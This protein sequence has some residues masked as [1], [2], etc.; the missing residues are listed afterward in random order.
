MFILTMYS[1]LTLQP[2][3]LGL[4]TE[5]NEFT[6]RKKNQSDISRS[7]ILKELDRFCKD[8]RSFNLTPFNS[9]GSLLKSLKSVSPPLMCLLSAL[10][11]SIF[12]S[13]KQQALCLTEG[14]NSFPE[15]YLKR[16]PTAPSM[17]ESSSEGLRYSFLFLF[18]MGFRWSGFREETL[19]PAGTFSKLMLLLKDTQ[20]SKKRSV[21][22]CNPAFDTQRLTVGTK[23]CHL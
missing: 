3:L 8:S 6:L 9:V 16:S 21:F 12:S 10:E 19:P 2:I 1:S 7:H 18:L 11:S 17:S 14:G 5:N 13:C 20:G 23:M 22:D 15:W 4:Y